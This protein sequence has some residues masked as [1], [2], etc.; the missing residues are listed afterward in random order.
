M[1]IDEKYFEENA[2][3][4]LDSTRDLQDLESVDFAKLRKSYDVLLVVDENGLETKWHFDV[5]D[6]MMLENLD[7]SYL[8]KNMPEDDLEFL[9]GPEK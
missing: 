6:C 1:D 3:V 9:D 8:E 4:L 7:F 2:L 5:A